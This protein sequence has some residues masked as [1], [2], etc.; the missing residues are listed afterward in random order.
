MFLRRIFRSCVPGFRCALLTTF[1]TAWIAG[2]AAHSAD[3]LSA[4]AVR[5]DIAATSLESALL[6]LSSQAN[7]QLVVAS[8]DIGGMA[9]PGLS[10]EFLL[11]DAL[12]RLLAGS[13]LTYRVD[14]AGTIIVTRSAANSPPV[15]PAS[16]HPTD[17]AAFRESTVLE[18]VVVTAQKRAESVQDVPMAMQALSAQE[19]EGRGIVSADQILSASPN[20][21]SNATSDVNTGFTIRGVGTNNYHGNV[22]RAVGVYQ[23]EVSMS[24]PFSGVLGVYDMERVEVMRGPQNTLFGR[25]T[26]GGA[27][28]YI[29]RKP[30]PGEGFNGYLLGTYGSY[31]QQNLEGAF[32]FDMGE[33]WAGRLSFQTVN[34]DGLFHNLATG[35]RHFGDRERHSGRLQIGWEPTADTRLMFN[36]H[37]GLN[38]GESLGNKGNGLLN[39]NGTLCSEINQIGDFENR[40]NCF[41]RG[42]FGGSPPF[43][44][45]TSDWHELYNTSSSR[46]DIDIGGGF[47]RVEHDFSSMS[48]VSLTSYDVTEVHFADD[49]SATNTFQFTPFQDAEYRTLTQELRL[50]SSS[51]G[52]LRAIGG[53]YFFKEELDQAT[54]V[55]RFV[56]NGNTTAFNL[57]DQE[58]TDI[59]AYGQLDYDFTPQLTFT[60]GLRYTD[61][62]KDADSRFGVAVTPLALYPSNTFITRELVESLTANA[63]ETCP[64]GAP[65][66]D[67]VTGRAFGGP[68]PCLLPLKHPAQSTRKLGGKLGLAWRMND[69]AMLYGNY[70]RG[71]KSGGFDTRALAAFGGD[72]ETGVA[73]ES[74]DAFEIGVKSELANSS[75]RLNAAAF[76]YVW[77]DLQTFATINSVPGFYNI[78]EAKIR[79]LEGELQWIP[80]EGWM[81][82]AG[83]G[84]LDTEITDVGSLAATIDAGHELPNSPEFSANALVSKR[85]SLGD[86]SLRLQLDARYISEQVDSLQFSLDPS[87]T[88]EAQT[89]LNARLS[90]AFGQDSRYEIRLFGE[91]LT[92]EKTCVD[93]G[94]FDDP[95]VTPA[96]LATLQTST[97]QCAPN[98]GSALWGVSARMAF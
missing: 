81:L 59:S 50:V 34:R 92:A 39:A 65:G 3:A 42:G 72:V 61:N 28:N 96:S 20:L 24:T 18:E 16:A 47:V 35:D 2:P 54:N 7:V 55:R 52:P 74:L 66:V 37:V 87:S 8:V 86:S 68:P 82:Q 94:P 48:L 83:F 30:E 53:L 11:K 69:D 56:N 51:D 98:D 89:Y 26:T 38:R 14:E 13:G 9:S 41:D 22:S 70:S 77:K 57:L 15:T 62:Q 44:P 1:V 46:A 63:P 21:N 27:I 73:P 91:N 67:P 31:N 25:N 32:G 23:D 12:D 75:V 88:N 49:A 60:V 93:I 40:N 58:D 17:T 95:T 80:A 45:S 6:Q 10:G 29:S 33:T 79:G 84:L 19:L 85:F 97:N 5:V 71:F 76:F 90:Y 43:N 36:Y 78:P 4:K 64:P